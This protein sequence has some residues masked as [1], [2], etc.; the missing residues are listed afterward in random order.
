M[1]KAAVCLHQLYSSQCL[2]EPFISTVPHTIVFTLSSSHRHLISSPH[3]L[4]S[5]PSS[6]SLLSPYHSPSHPHCSHHHNSIAI[7]ILAHLH[8][9]QHP[10]TSPDSIAIAIVLFRSSV[11][12]DQPQCHF[13]IVCDTL[14]SILHLLLLLLHVNKHCCIAGLSS[15]VCA[16]VRISAW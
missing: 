8:I 11:C 4:T 5:S 12:C 3:H 14:F 7:F 16:L 1:C 10:T 2:L 13:N 9:T 15:L 6:P